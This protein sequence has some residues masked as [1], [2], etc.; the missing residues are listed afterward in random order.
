MKSDVELT[1][2]ESGS[3]EVPLLCFLNHSEHKS[4]HVETTGQGDR[5]DVRHI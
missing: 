5:G 3:L 2:P 1:V 4:T